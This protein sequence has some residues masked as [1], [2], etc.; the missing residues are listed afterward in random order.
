MLYEKSFKITKVSL[1]L[2]VSNTMPDTRDNQVQLTDPVKKHNWKHR[3]I[4]LLQLVE[5]N[6]ST[7]EIKGKLDSFRREEEALK[8]KLSFIEQEIEDVT[9]QLNE[10]DTGDEDKPI[11]SNILKLYKLITKLTFAIEKP[12]TDLQ[13]YVAGNSL[14]TFHLDTTKQ[15]KQ[16]IIDHLWQLIY[17]QLELE[18]E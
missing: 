1:K 4:D 10:T 14:E 3:C 16:F 13:G 11:N 2:K 8:K 17:S 15:S 6:S 12:P 7:K 9:K 18:K 5:K